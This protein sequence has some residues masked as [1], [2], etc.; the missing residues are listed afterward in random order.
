MRIAGI[1][2][3]IPTVYKQQSFL[4]TEAYHFARKA[5]IVV[6]NLGTDDS[7]IMKGWSKEQIKS[8]FK[9]TARDFVECILEKNGADRKIVSALGMMTNKKRVL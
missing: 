9:A 1:N 2:G 7:G 3:F 4:K 8:T 5:E 6:V